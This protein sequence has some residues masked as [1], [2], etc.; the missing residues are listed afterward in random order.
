MEHAWN[1]EVN[2]HKVLAL[3]INKASDNS[4]K[5]KSWCLKD[6]KDQ[7]CKDNGE[8][9]QVDDHLSADQLK[10]KEMM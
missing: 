8:V 5:E 6:A 9:V 4:S 1:A 7:I 2:D 10:S 3:E